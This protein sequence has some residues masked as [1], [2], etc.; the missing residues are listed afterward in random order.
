MCTKS[1]AIALGCRVSGSYTDNQLVKYSDL[2]PNIINLTIQI[3]A[4]VGGRYNENDDCEIQIQFNPTSSFTGIVEFDFSGINNQYFRE[5][6]YEHV[7]FGNKGTL[8]T[9]YNIANRFI[10]N[11]VIPLSQIQASN[12]TPSNFK[13]TLE[14]I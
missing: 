14:N 11:Q 6:I 1:R 4:F 10:N 7:S 3:R 2:S 5:G 12:V 8:I 9:S 13:L